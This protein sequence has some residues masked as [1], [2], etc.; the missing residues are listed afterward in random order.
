MRV[1][2][3]VSGETAVTDSGDRRWRKGGG[4][5]AVGEAVERRWTGG[6]RRPSNHLQVG[7]G[8]AGGVEG[9]L[10]VAEGS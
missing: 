5:T 2:R 7:G 9:R 10:K 1:R 6:E 3:K 8:V 4:R